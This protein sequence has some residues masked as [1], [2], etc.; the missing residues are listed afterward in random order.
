MPPPPLRGSLISSF[1]RKS[2][3]HHNITVT[4]RHPPPPALGTYYS[5]SLKAVQ[6]GFNDFELFTW[7]LPLTQLLLS[8]FSKG[9]NPLQEHQV[10][11][12]F[13]FSQ[14]LI[15]NPGV[16]INSVALRVYPWGLERLQWNSRAR[17]PGTSPDFL[18]VLLTFYLWK[19]KGFPL[20]IKQRKHPKAEIVRIMRCEISWSLTEQEAL[21]PRLGPSLSFPAE[22]SAASAHLSFAVSVLWATGG[23]WANTDV[24]HPKV[25]ACCLFFFFVFFF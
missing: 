22:S 7:F 24:S 6:R 4:G 9:N 2:D 19:A 18:F 5:H 11:K 3:Q 25:M 21:H 20:G 12:W 1:Q 23:S 8:E 13:I 17:D 14:T 16:G 15:F 10:S